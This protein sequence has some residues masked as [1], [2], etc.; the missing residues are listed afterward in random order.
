MSPQPPLER[1]AEPNNE[2]EGRGPRS[3]SSSDCQRWDERDRPHL[4]QGG[5]SE[6]SCGHRRTTDPLGQRDGDAKSHKHVKAQPRHWA[7]QRG[8]GYPHPGRANAP[9]TNNGQDDGVDSEHGQ[10]PGHE[11]HARGIDEGERCDHLLGQAGVLVEGGG[12]VRPGCP[13]PI[14]T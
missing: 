3:P 11:V 6:R 4:R 7:E 13:S 8:A 2:R 1:H 5:Q 9:T 12:R 14:A 10:D